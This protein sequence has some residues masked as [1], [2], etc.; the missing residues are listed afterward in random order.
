MG[1]VSVLVHGTNFLKPF[2]ALEKFSTGRRK[3]VLS[4]FKKVKDFAEI[5]RTA[6]IVH[7]CHQ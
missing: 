6:H 2:Y 1:F 3:V 4:R 7:T 5:N